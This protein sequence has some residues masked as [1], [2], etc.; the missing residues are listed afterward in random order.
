MSKHTAYDSID[1]TTDVSGRKGVAIL[2]L[3][4]AV[5]TVAVFA[6]LVAI[7]VY[8]GSQTVPVVP[9][10]SSAV[11]GAHHSAPVATRPAQGPAAPRVPEDDPRWNCATMGG[12]RCGQT[13]P[14]SFRELTTLASR[15]PAL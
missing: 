12:H 3:A 4:V 8:H 1:Q 9:A 10:V 13:T 15:W 7:S 5:V 6:I 14:T 11:Q 2:V